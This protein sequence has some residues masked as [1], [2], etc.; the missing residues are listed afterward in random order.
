[1]DFYAIVTVLFWTMHLFYLFI[2]L[3]CGISF[4]FKVCL[5]IKF[6]IKRQT[7]VG[8]QCLYF[9]KILEIISIFIHL[10]INN[11]ISSSL[12]YTLSHYCT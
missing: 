12:L 3:Y 11:T 2:F 4:I 5:I 10:Q 7:L 6:Y 9:V 8:T 1:M